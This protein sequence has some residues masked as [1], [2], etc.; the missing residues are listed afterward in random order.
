MVNG[1][2]TEF[3]ERTAE[4]Q[5]DGGTLSSIT[6]FGEDGS[7]ELY[8]VTRGGRIY[9]IVPDGELAKG[10][11]NGNG[12]I[13]AEDIEPFILALFDRAQYLINFP[14]INPDVTGDFNC[15]GVMDTEDIEGFIIVLFP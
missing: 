7:G 12:V 15:D 8:I 14:D 11:L 6:S 9:K 10:D 13:D 4:L 1:N 3:E 2:V 5:P